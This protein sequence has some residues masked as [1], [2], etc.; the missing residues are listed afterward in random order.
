MRILAH[1]SDLH[2][3]T[4][5]IN[6]AEGL[7]SDLEAV[8]PHLVIISGDLTQRAR[9]KQFI[10]AKKYLQKINFP[11]IVIPGN[12]DIPFFDI[13]SRIFSPLK[14]FK[15]YI[16][17]ELNPFYS[18]EEIVVLGLNTAR[19]LTWKE[20]RIS[21]EQIKDMHM[22]MCSS[23]DKCLK[24][25][26]THHPF[27]P[28][29]EDLG[30]KLVGRAVKAITI[31]DK[32]NVDLLLAGHLHNGY[33]GDIRPYYPRAKSSVIVIQAGTAIS[34]RRRNEPNGYN[35][36]FAEEK[37]VIINVREWTSTRFNTSHTT[38]YIKEKLEWKRID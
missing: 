8:K 4:E 7:L 28:P 10:E 32:C 24:I 31:I 37:K 30:I 19:S 17:E 26:I 5:D 1:L 35:L 22:K 11:K 2:F 21:I 27:I 13:F 6:V 36:I 33:T 14:R 38:T 16:S 15:K 20:G 23:H 29:P 25:V 34:Q 9:K 3:G 12:H 18:D